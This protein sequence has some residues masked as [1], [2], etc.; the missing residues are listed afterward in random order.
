MAILEFS[1][2]ASH[3]RWRRCA[4]SE[5]S[6]CGKEGVV[7]RKCRFQQVGSR[8]R[9]AR[10]RRSFGRREA[11][12]RVAA[13]SQI[14]MSCSMLEREA[15]FVLLAREFKWFI[16]MKILTMILPGGEFSHE[17]IRESKSLVSSSEF[18]KG[19]NSEQSID[20]GRGG[21]RPSKNR[22]N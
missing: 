14:C 22:K 5:N 11:H 17:P 12:A 3:R 8:E 20:G 16:V 15:Y 2:R 7:S 18:R 1:I 9:A 13:P 6:R 4:R 10:N 19:A 21:T